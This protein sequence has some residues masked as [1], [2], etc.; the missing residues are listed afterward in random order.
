MGR[1]V[2]TLNILPNMCLIIV[3]WT[4]LLMLL[5]VA[6]EVHGQEQ[7]EI[8]PWFTECDRYGCFPDYFCNFEVNNSVCELCP[9]TPAEECAPL[10]GLSNNLG[11]EDCLSECGRGQ[12]G[13]PCSEKNQCEE[14]SLFCNFQNGDSGTCEKCKT[15]LS[16]CLLEDY[17]DIISDRGRQDCLESCDLKCVPMHF[18][19]NFVDGAK[20]TSTALVGSPSTSVSGPVV[21]CTNLIYDGQPTC[22]DAN[23]SVCLVEDYTKNTYYVDVVNKCA[24]SGGVAV[25][26]FGQYEDGKGTDEPFGGFLSYK[27]TQIPSISI[28]YNDGIH[29]QQSEIGSHANI[30]VSSAGDYCFKEQTCSE[31]IPCVGENAG[32][33]CNFKWG[34][35]EGKCMTCPEDD[36]GEPDPIACFFTTSEWGEVTGQKAVESCAEVCASNLK[37]RKCKYC[38]Q[39]VSG[40]KFGV[41]RESDQ[42]QFCPEND[43]TYPDRELPLFVEGLQCWQMQKFF[44]TVEVNSD[45]T[46]CLLAQTMNYICGCKGPGYA[47]A[48]TETKKVVLAWL[49]RVMAMLSVLGSSFIIYDALSSKKN[50]QKVL[51]QLMIALS[52]SDILGSCAYA[53]TTLPTPANT[54]MYGAK[55]NDATCVAQGFFIQ[56]GTISCYINVSVA[57]YY[58]LVIKMGRTE[59]QM[60]KARIWLFTCPIL[61]GLTFAFA[62]IPFYG[63]TIL[64][65]NTTENWWPEVPVAIAILLATAIMATVCWDVYQKEK[66]SSR[67]RISGVEGTARNKLSEQVFWQSFWYLMAFYFTWPPYLVLQYLLASRNT[68]VFTMY[69]LILTAGTMVPLQGFWNA[70]VYIRPRHLKRIR[71]SAPCLK[72]TFLGRLRTFGSQNT[73]PNVSPITSH[74][75]N[76]ATKEQPI[77]L[78]THV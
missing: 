36:N 8:H 77:S 66:A 31:T 53:L 17:V 44:K 6:Q 21:D 20:I 18:S 34:G 35:D 56:L 39:D 65:C 42:C 62:G 51:Y 67:W 19:S 14:K 68:K 30:S 49:P 70:F 50:R 74:N 26:F 2:F 9:S 61:I 43:V 45:S 59:R 7:Q 16:E 24:S 11:V 55:G 5:L 58:L 40:F 33:F 3:G 76:S 69:G 54:F 46:N 12:E 41:K 38:P 75:S 57:V 28:S 71:K 48:S 25:V 13:E 72:F 37:F 78:D 47:G 52:I 60:K 1:I 73:S 10:L 22:P 63:N 23:N 29:L 27:Q 15:D 32:K 64:W 4:M